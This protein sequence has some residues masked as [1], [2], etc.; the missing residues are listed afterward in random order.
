[1]IVLDINPPA[2]EEN[3]IHFIECD[4]SNKQ[5]VT[6]VI[7]SIKEKFGIPTILV[8]NAGICHGKTLLELTA[9]EIDK[10]IDVNLKGQIWMIKAVLPDMI[11]RNRGHIVNIASS[12]GFA[13]TVRVGDYA[14]SKA[15]VYILSESLRHELRAAKA[16]GVK[17]TVICAGFIST[18]LFQGVKMKYPLLTPTLEPKWMADRIIQAIINQEEEVWTPLFVRGIPLLRLLPTWFYDIIQDQV[19]VSGAMENFEG[20]HKTKH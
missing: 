17:T 18:R 10:T 1:V 13:G 11:Q 7:G 14:A 19:G 6:D 3:G 4:V 2:I 5:Q 15:G 12:L 9:E 8:N 16:D 20:V